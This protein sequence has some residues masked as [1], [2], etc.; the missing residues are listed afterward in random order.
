MSSEGVIDF[1]VMAIK[2][3]CPCL[4]DQGLEGIKGAKF[5][6]EANFYNLFQALTLDVIG[7][8]V[9]ILCIIAKGLLE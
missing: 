6:T 5:Q 7:N 2:I 9:H 3:V 1:E 4:F 8:F